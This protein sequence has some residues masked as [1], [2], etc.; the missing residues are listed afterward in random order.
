MTTNPTRT[1]N[2]SKNSTSSEIRPR[3]IAI[4]AISEPTT[5]FVGHRNKTSGTSSTRFICA[6]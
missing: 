1:T 6:A 5:D 4:A 2:V 3:R